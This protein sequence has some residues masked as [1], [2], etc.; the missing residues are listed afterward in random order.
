M[1]AFEDLGLLR[2]FTCIVECGSISAAS[3]RLK[4]SQP[5]LSRH[6]K[7]LEERCGTALLRRDTHRMSLTE[8]GHRLLADAQA[9][10][11]H[12]EEADH[13]LREDQT[14]LSGHLR[15]FATID[16]GQWV[17]TRLLSQFL[18]AHPKVT[19]ELA[20]T[21]RP[22]HMVQ[23]GCDVGILPGKITD[24]SAV[25]RLAGAITLQLVAAPSLV[26]R[27]PSTRTPAELKTWPWISLAGSQFWSAKDIRLTAKNGTEQSLR[28]S[29]VLVSEGV[30]SVREATLTGLGISLLP[31]WLVRDDL[32]A[33]HLVRVLPQ[34][35]ARDLPVHVVYSGQRALPARVRAFVEFA[36]K[37]MKL[38]LQGGPAQVTGK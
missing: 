25:A 17:V 30:T 36:L 18:Q 10:L 27:M 12:A 35:R 32:A 33:G 15:V 38:E 1:T 14:T 29:P 6:L 20:L 9:L 31:D 3:R 28:V 23:E 26:K 19:A 7:E 37:A 34:W 13:R 8:T 5:T 21:N 2:A 22:L 16:W 11:A 24:E 4:T